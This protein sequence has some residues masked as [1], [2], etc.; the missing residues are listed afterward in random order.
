MKPDIA[1]PGVNVASSISSF[2]DAS[3]ST[4]ETITFNGVEYDFA[5]FSGTSMSS[6]CVAGIVALLLDA[7]PGLTPFEI[8]Q[9][10]QATAREDD[11]TGGGELLPLQGAFR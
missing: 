3:Y 4:T 6:P 7:N 9:I 1:A 2:T 10:L 11:E 5:K 8:K